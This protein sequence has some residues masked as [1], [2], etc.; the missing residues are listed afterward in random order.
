[1]RPGW[2]QDEAADLPWLASVLGVPFSALRLRFRCRKRH[3]TFKRSA[4]RPRSY[5][6]RKQRKKKALRNPAKLS[7]HEYRGGG[8]RGIL[9]S[10]PPSIDLQHTWQ[11]CRSSDFVRVVVG[12]GPAATQTPWIF[13]PWAKIPGAIPAWILSVKTIDVKGFLFFYSR[14]VFLRFQRSLFVQCFL[15]LKTLEK[16]HTHLRKQQVEMTFHFVMQS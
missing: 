9:G 6:S 1:M 5:S 13:G 7:S 11:L 14:Q 3:L 15:F 12:G 8:G 16:R 10:G 4:A 2:G